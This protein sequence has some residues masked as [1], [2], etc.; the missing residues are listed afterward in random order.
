MI[1]GYLYNNEIQIYN[2]SDDEIPL[3]TDNLPAEP[4]NSGSILYIE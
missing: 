2:S 3:H 4:N 1:D